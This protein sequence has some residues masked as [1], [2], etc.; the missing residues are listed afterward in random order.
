ML[1]DTSLRRFISPPKVQHEHQYSSFLLSS[2][3]L[4]YPSNDA[5]RPLWFSTNCTHSW[6]TFL[7][8]YCTTQC[9]V[10][11]KTGMI[12]KFVP[13]FFVFRRISVCFVVFRRISPCFGVFR[14]VSAYFAMFRCVSSY[15]GCLHGPTDD[16]AGCALDKIP[17]CMLLNSHTCMRS[18]AVVERHTPSRTM[19][20][21]P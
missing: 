19:L 21:V 4:L 13:Y 3:P 12:L 20:A 10:S 18:A 11:W 15:F 1:V 9:L 2:L 17:S 14:R 5:F 8:I 6:C 16:A 7:L